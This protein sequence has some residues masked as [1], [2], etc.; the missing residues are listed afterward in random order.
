MYTLGKSR[1][2]WVANNNENNFSRESIWKIHK[3]KEKIKT[4]KLQCLKMFQRHNLSC[5]GE[6]KK[7]GEK[8]KNKSLSHGAAATG[9]F[10]IAAAADSAL[11]V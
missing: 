2:V 11:E 7:E 3:Q 5:K 1:N 6:N 4:T 10:F 8:K 9:S